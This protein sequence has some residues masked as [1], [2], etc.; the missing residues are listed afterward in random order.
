MF[1]DSARAKLLLATVPFLIA[2]RAA[3]AADGFEAVRCGSDVPRALIGKM[4]IDEPVVKTEARHTDLGLKDLGADEINDDLYTISWSICGKEYVVLEDSRG[5]IRDAIAFPEHA[6]AEPEFS[7]YDCR[8]N[9]KPVAGVA[10]AVLQDNSAADK[11]GSNEALL[12]AQAAWK[13]DERRKTFVRLP[14]VGLS[15][16][17][18]GIVTVD[19]GQ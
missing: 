9:G 7:G 1:N 17:R 11:E 18:R 2:M 5:V 3:H 10:I 16:P 12:P 19:G 13:I 15:C 14:T 8:L 6:K 4:T